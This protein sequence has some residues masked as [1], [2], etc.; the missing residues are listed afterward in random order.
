MSARR[1][2]GSIRKL[3]SGR[4]QAR[5]PGPSG[6]LVAAPSTFAARADAARY[7]ARVQADLE[8]GHWQDHRLGRV[9]FGVWMDRWLASNP[10]KR[11]T[12][13]ARDSTVLRTH[14]LPA[15]GSRP[16]SSIT[17]RDVKSVVDEMA[18]KLA[19]G[20]CARTSP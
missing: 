12:T 4:W 11:S 18:T 9:T 19:P 14:A 8:R 7:L 3:P 15:L 1:Q 5:Y 10:S 20:T 6:A 2:F 13:L 17:P 16:M